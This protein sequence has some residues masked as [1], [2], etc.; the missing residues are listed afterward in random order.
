MSAPQTPTFL[1]PPP[2]VALAAWLIPG[3]GYWLIGQRIRGFVVGV[4]ILL[5]FVAGLLI[6]GMH[7]IE[8]PTG[9]TLPLILQKPWIIPQV[10]TGPVTIFASYL[11]NN[12]GSYID[13]IS[14]QKTAGVALS[15]ARVNEIGVLYTAV[16]GMLNLMAI[17]DAAYRSSNEGGR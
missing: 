17:I 2:L 1:P 5:L 9:F 11:A 12:W 10:M 8:S 16:A 14:L 7:V 15:H 6:G 13:P 4:T 3:A